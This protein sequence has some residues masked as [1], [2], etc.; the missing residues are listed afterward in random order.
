MDSPASRPLRLT[1]KR[2]TA[3]VSPS[4]TSTPTF[5]S[6]SVMFRIR[7]ADGAPDSLVDDVSSVAELRSQVRAQRRIPRVWNRWERKFLDVSP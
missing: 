1:K 2:S 6:H 3:S 4:S 5:A 7:W